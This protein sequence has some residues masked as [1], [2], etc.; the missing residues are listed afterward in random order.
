MSRHN[1]NLKVE[2]LSRYSNTLS[3]HGMRRAHKETVELCHDV[4]IIVVTKPKT[5]N[6]KIILTY[7]H[8]FAKKNKVD[9]RKTLLRHS[10]LCH[11]RRREESLNVH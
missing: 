7:V 2:A 9:G 10:N 5:K 3:R 11:D 1:E 6:K 4:D 8:F